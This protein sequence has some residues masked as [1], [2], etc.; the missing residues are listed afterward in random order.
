[1]ITPENDAGPSQAAK[2]LGLTLLDGWVW[3]IEELSDADCAGLDDPDWEMDCRM[4]R[5]RELILDFT[6]NL[7]APL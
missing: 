6:G 1:M 7:D 4:A 2:Y 5:D 3:R